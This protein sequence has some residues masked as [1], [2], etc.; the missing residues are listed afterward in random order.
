MNSA[1]PPGLAGAM[2]PSFGR[3]ALAWVMAL[4]CLACWPAAHAA[5][6]APA[7][8]GAQVLQ[9]FEQQPQTGAAADATDRFRREVMFALGVPLL[10]ML[11]TTGALGIAVGVYGKPLY[12]LHMLCA[13]LS[14]TLAVVHAIVG[15]V[16]FYPF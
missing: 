13:G 1:R 9:A 12:A 15:L 14:V 8:S 11:L 4:L 16:W 7:S 2:R 6:P 3:I 5:E 10:L